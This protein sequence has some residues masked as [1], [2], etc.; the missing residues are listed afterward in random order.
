MIF[1]MSHLMFDMLCEFQCT[2]RNKFDIS[3]QI[4]VL[5]LITEICQET[6]TRKQMIVHIL[7]DKIKY[8]LFQI[9]FP[10]FTVQYRYFLDNGN[11]TKINKCLCKVNTF[12]LSRICY[13]FKIFVF[14]KI[15]SA[16]NYFT[17]HTL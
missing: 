5:K 3:H 4:I 7:F 15:R 6:K 8:V 17:E 9:T 10:Y 1:I 13:N 16:S 2:W 12:H 14:C 11:V